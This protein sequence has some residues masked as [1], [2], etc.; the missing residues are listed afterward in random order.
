MSHAQGAKAGKWAKKHFAFGKKGGLYSEGEDDSDLSDFD[1]RN[2]HYG[3]SSSSDVDGGG[4]GN[5]S[6]D[7]ER[8]F[9]DDLGFGLGGGV[10]GGAEATR[11]RKKKR[12]S[13]GLD[14]SGACQRKT[15][16]ALLTSE[17][18]DYATSSFPAFSAGSPDAQFFRFFM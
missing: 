5:S 18:P 11:S 15:A 14:S 17:P 4:R 6:E 3:P 12:R 2:H 1:D 10:E 13:S 8:G 16:V 9:E 7:E